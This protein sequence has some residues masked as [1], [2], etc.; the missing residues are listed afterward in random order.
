MKGVILAGGTGSRLYPLTKAVNK[1]LLPVG[2]EPMICHGIRKLKDAGIEDVLVVSGRNHL[3][4]MVKLLEDG[5]EFGVSLTYRAQEEAGGIAQALAL[6]EGFADGGPVAVLLGDNIFADGLSPY[7]ARFHKQGTG[8]KVLLKQVP[9]P[10]RYGVAELSGPFI[11]SIEEKPQAPKSDYAVTG[12]YLYDNQ[13][14][15]FI[16]TIRPSAR[17]ELEITDVNNL[18]IDCRQ[19]SYDILEGWWT[20]AGTHESLVLANDLVRGRAVQQP[21]PE[22]R[23]GGKLAAVR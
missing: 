15:D 4:D 2:D 20:D 21:Q 18:Y 1:H 3:G 12:I 8:A 13:V 23:A 11:V 5:S 19:L 22:P 6:A 10:D 16:R 9:D 14:F 7:V 17:G